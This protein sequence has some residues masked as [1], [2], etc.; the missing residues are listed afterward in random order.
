MV[1]PGIAS[2]SMPKTCCSTA[3]PAANM[4]P[5]SI[6]S[7]NF[8]SVRSTWVLRYSRTAGRMLQ[9]TKA[10]I[11]AVPAVGC[12]TMARTPHH[13]ISIDSAMNVGVPCLCRG[14]ITTSMN[15]AMNS[16]NSRNGNGK[17]PIFTPALG[18]SAVR[19]PSRLARVS[20]R[21]ENCRQNTSTAAATT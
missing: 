12:R 9:A 7:L 6:E 16:P 19:N 11:P 1:R 3:Y 8:R 21:L 4:N 2:R 17:E 10:A 18:N 20:N 15:T 13:R 14:E 5:S